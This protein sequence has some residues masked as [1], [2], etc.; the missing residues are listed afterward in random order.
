MPSMAI[1]P[2]K[3]VCSHLQQR[4]ERVIF[5]LFVAF[6]VVVVTLFLT[7]DGGMVEDHGAPESGQLS[8]VSIRNSKDTGSRR[9]SSGTKSP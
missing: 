9:R 1:C 2:L 5:G 7:W 4:I 3:V 6:V 8:R